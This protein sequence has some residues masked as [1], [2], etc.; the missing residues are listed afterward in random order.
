MKKEELI[1]RPRW[2]KIII[3]FSIIFAVLF[4]TSLFSDVKSGNTAL[5]PINGMITGNGGSYVGQ[6]TVSSKDITNYI[7]TAEED[8]QIKVMVLEINSPGG[9]AVASDEIASAIKKVTKP[10]VTIIREAGASGGYWIASAT[11]HIIANKMSITGSIGVISSYLEFSGLM[12]EY[13]IGYER[14]VTGD[15]K[16]IGSPL[17]ESSD[18]EKTILQ[19]KL[20]KIH[21]IFIQEIATNRGMSVADVQNLATGE[22]Y[23]GIE[24]FELG[25]IDQLGDENTLEQYI[26]T[27]FAL[28]EVDYL[29]YKKEPSLLDAFAGVFTDFS[30]GIGEGIGSI[31]VKGT[32]K[33]M[34]I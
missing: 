33:L 17:K 31:L 14:L 22:F 4:F 9:S 7:K 34:L 5:I 1:K 28:E 23:L 24:A 18:E 20:D 21:E 6:T 27:N 25:L 29:V 12:D 8:P 2:K 13:G 11:E 16:D 32:N 19:S 10:T 26:K 15:Y 30:F 3:I